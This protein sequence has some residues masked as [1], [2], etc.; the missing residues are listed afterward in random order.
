MPQ[1][2]NIPQLV[3]GDCNAEKF[4]NPGEFGSTIN[5]YAP[6]VRSVSG[7]GTQ[8]DFKSKFHSVVVNK[9]RM[10]AFSHSSLYV[11]KCEE[12]DCR[13]WV[14]LM[15]EHYHNNEHG[16]YRLVESESILFDQSHDKSIKST[17]GSSVVIHIDVP[18][19][20]GTINAMN[21]SAQDT[22]NDLKTDGSTILPLFMCG[23]SFNQIFLNI[24]NQVDQL[25]GQPNALAMSGIDE[26]V[27]RTIV[28]MMNKNLLDEK[29]LNDRKDLGVRTEIR[30]LC[31]YL[32]T[33]L[34]DPIN[35][36]V[37]EKVSGLS[38]RSLQYGFR[39]YFG[40]RP[41]EWLRN[42]RLNLAKL[43]LTSSNDNMNITTLVYDLGFP[44]ASLFSK[45]Y[46]EKFGERPSET[47]ARKKQRMTVSSM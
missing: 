20:N 33:H 42:E 30:R 36:T 17:R 31:D 4:N 13:I 8:N 18:R 45:Y 25:N 47:L 19:L 16:T 38:S 5:K 15:G 26:I 22:D 43:K 24:F 41:C 28:L 40:C 7:L 39:K 27:Y 46:K 3:F 12:D 6:R 1:Y 11:E 10:M 9:T 23:I 34:E 29:H 44:S 14:P 35:L 32:K 2:K 21:G 37:M